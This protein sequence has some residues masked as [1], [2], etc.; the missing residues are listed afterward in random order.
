[1]TESK[2]TPGPW[3]VR[4]EGCHGNEL[5][6]RSTVQTEDTCDGGVYELTVADL[7]RDGGGR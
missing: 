7:H 1:M 5:I 2:H 3:V 6:V 4:Y